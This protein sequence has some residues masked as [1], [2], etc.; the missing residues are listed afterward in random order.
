MGDISVI[1]EGIDSDDAAKGY[2]STVHGAGLVMSRTA[3]AGRV[4][5]KKPK[6][7]GPMIPVV[8]KQGKITRQMMEEWIGD[9]GV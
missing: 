4:R 1:V 7:G 6:K 3:A 8:Q 9:W 2:H 5:W